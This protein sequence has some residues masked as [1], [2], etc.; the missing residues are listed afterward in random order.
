MTVDIT[1]TQLFLNFWIAI[2]PCDFELSV[3]FGK[4]T[5]NETLIDF[6][7]GVTRMLT[8]VDSLKIK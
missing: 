2:D 5:Y 7:L 6:D 8:V 1:I 4:W 3:G